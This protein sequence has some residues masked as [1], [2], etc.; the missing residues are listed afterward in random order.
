[1]GVWAKGEPDKQIG[2][3]TCDLRSL[4]N[5]GTNEYTFDLTNKGRPVGSI[6]LQFNY[7]NETKAHRI[8]EDVKP[9][10]PGVPT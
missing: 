6:T 1:M 8:G 2:E 7:T 4:L 5:E 9:H 3:F 10:P